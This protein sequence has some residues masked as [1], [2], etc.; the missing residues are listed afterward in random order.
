MLKTPF[1]K[2]IMMTE[3]S[4]KVPPNCLGAPKMFVFAF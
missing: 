3:N 4:N 1:D 2:I